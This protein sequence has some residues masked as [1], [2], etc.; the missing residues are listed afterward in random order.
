MRRIALPCLCLALAGCGYSTWSDPP[1]STG[2]N[3]HFPA[4]DS[5]NMRRVMGARVETPVLTPE[6]GDIWPGPLPPEPTLQELEQQGEQSGPERPVPGSPQFQAAPPAEP[7]AAALAWQFDA[8]KVEP[9]GCRQAT[10]PDR[11]TAGQSGA[12]RSQS[13]RAGHANATG[14]G[15]HL[16]GHQRL[17]DYPDAGRRF[18]NRRAQWQW[19]QH[20]HTFGRQDRDCPHT[21]LSCHGRHRRP[22]DHSVFRLAARADRHLGGERNA[23]C[24]RAHRR[25]SDRMA[26]R[27][28]PWPRERLRQPPHGALRGEPGFRRAHGA[29]S[30][31]A[32]RWRS[33]RR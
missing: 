6:P 15:S 28:Q 12:A 14:P 21:T 17:S 11:P 24:R 13:G 25:R 20:D 31:P 19:H 16:G 22:A 1:F 7:A 33:F 9:A 26:R 29:R 30:A 3:P 18:S 5:E 4:G 2:S 23:A 27:A 32:T 10:G 8:A